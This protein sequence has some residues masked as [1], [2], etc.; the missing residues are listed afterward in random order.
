MSVLVNKPLVTDG[1][2]MRDVMGVFVEGIAV[3]V[4]LALLV[5][6]LPVSHVA[7]WHDHVMV[8]GKLT[9]GGLEGHVVGA[10]HSPL[11]G[12]KQFMQKV[13]KGVKF[14]GHECLQLKL[15]HKNLMSALQDFIALR[16]GH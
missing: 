12:S 4:G 6:C 15:I 11:H 13:G 2:V 16:V 10:V 7:C 9:G 1:V 8:E 5:K 14:D 3:G